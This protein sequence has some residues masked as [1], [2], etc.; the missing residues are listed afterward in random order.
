MATPATACTFSQPDVATLAVAGELTFATAARAWREGVQTL[1]ADLRTTRLDLGRV[2]RA[3]S[4]GLACVIALAAH[5]RRHGGALAV[6]NWPA[7]LHALAAVCGV[8]GLL[9]GERQPTQA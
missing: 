4:A 2:Q 9:E 5:A 6:V 8:D 1:D 3:D 7:G